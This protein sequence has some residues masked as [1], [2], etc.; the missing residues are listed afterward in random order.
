[1]CNMEYLTDQGDSALAH[2]DGLYMHSF[3]GGRAPPNS[4]MYSIRQASARRMLSLMAVYV[5]RNH[6]Y[7]VSTSCWLSA[8]VHSLQD[9]HAKDC[10]C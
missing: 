3:Q 6:G 2:I 4:Y 10:C 9:G 1:M 7:L 5:S 8:S